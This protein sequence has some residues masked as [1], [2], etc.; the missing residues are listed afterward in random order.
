M[1]MKWYLM[2]LLGLV[3]LIFTGCGGNTGDQAAAEQAL[4]MYLEH[5]ARGEYSEVAAYYGGNYDVLMSVNPAVNPSE[6]ETLW[7]QACEINGFQCLETRS[8]TFQEVN[9]QGE[10]V[11]VVQ[12]SDR[13]G[14]L[15]VLGPCCGDESPSRMTDFIFRVVEKEAGYKVLDL[16]VYIP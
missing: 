1:K 7:M 6:F 5:L 16:P 3:C 12:F 9:Q 14:D 2:N 11:F 4:M 8:I 15:F 10:Y 13:G